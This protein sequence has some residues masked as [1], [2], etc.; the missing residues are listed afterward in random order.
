[1]AKPQLEHGHLRVANELFEALCRA[2]LSGREFQVVLAIM[3][4]T[5]G[6]QKKAGTIS[7]KQ[8][9]Q[10]T[11]ITHRPWL[12]RILQRLE[13]Q[14]IILGAHRLGYATAYQINKDYE[15]WGCLLHET[16]PIQETCPAGGGVTPY[17]CTGRG[18]LP[19][20]ENIQRHVKD[21]ERKKEPPPAIAGTNTVDGESAETA[22]PAPPGG[23]DGGKKECREYLLFLCNGGRVDDVGWQSLE[24][25]MTEH[26]TEHTLEALKTAGNN[27]VRGQRVLAYIA[28]VL[29][30]RQDKQSRWM[31]G[32][33]V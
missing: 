10:M 33:S 30:K 2:T 26:G 6:W 16:C 22:E 32:W 5:Y 18:P 4:L 24:D 13:S 7:L 20:D 1:M 28:K 21:R 19:M 11:G 23:G 15:Q 27:G 8:L 25:M 14:R 9:Q 3:R 12:M 29:S 17:P 31:M